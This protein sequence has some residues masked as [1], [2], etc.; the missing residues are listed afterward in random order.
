MNRTKVKKTH[1]VIIIIR[2]E[3]T[4]K[5]KDPTHPPKF[6]TGFDPFQK[7]EAKTG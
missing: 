1:L 3:D 7:Q 2:P 4:H 5:K 6:K